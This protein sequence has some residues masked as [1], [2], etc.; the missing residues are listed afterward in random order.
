MYL[1]GFVEVVIFTL[2]KSYGVFKSIWLEI[3]T[4]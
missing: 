4:E 1:Q 3:E 2:Y